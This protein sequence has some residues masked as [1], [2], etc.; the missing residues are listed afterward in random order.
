MSVGGYIVGYVKLP[1]LMN[2]LLLMKTTLPWY[3]G[4]QLLPS[5]IYDHW[6]KQ[7]QSTNDEAYDSNNENYELVDVVV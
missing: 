3:S 5:C 1:E 2:S 4:L 7:I 6:V